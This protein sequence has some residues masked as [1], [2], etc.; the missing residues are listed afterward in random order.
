MKN[1]LNALLIFLVM[2]QSSSAFQ[3][4]IFELPKP[5]TKIVGLSVPPSIISGEAHDKIL[6]KIEHNLNAIKSLKS[7]F[8]QYGP[9]GDIEQGTIFLE[10]PG[11]I[12]FEYAGENPILVVSDGEM[13]SFIDYEIKQ[14][15]RWPVDKTPLSLLVDEYIDL[16]NKDIEIPEIVRF[17]GLI[18]VSVRRLNQKELG[19]ITLIFEEKSMDLKSWEIVDTQ[20]YTTRI[21]LHNPEYNIS[22]DN[23]KFTF[24]DPRIKRNRG[25]RR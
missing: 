3:E 24:D 13:L 14:V 4:N 23:I 12:R 21:T 17:S 16:N 25:P 9:Q 19:Y 6:K 5:K 15:S 2:S 1:T 11:K 7:S 10:R 8:I 18:K 22:V 20:G